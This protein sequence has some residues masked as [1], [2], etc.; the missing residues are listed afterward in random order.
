MHGV[1]RRLERRLLAGDMIHMFW[2]NLGGL[3]MEIVGG[4]LGAL[5]RGRGDAPRK[6]S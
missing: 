4:I 5:G 1:R 3:V 2:T 6:E